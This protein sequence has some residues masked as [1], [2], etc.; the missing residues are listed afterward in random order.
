ME[1]HEGIEHAD[2]PGGAQWT[3]TAVGLIL[4]G[5]LPKVL[6]DT[7]PQVCLR[8]WDKSAGRDRKVRVRM[9]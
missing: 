4:P 1:P 2:P 7:P 3:H 6:A 9:A 8:L 5:Q